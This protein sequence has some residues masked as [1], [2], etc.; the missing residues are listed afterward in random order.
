MAKKFKSI[1]TGL[2]AIAVLSMSLQSC[3]KDQEDVFDDPAAQRLTDYLK[4]AQKVLVGAENGWRMY[5]YPDQKQ[6]YGGFVYTL[7]FTEDEVTV[8]SEIFDG[9]YTSK[10][11][12][13]RD[14]SAV[15]SFDTNNYAFHYFATPSGS[16]RNL[17]NESGLYQAYKGD[18][19]FLILSATKDEVVLK[20]KRS[21][22]LIKMYP[23]SA[24][25]DAEQVT[26]DV[27]NTASSVYVSQFV[28]E[29][30]G[31]NYL[32]YLDLDYRWISLY[33]IVTNDEGEE[34]AESEPIAESAFA[35][36][37]TGLKLYTPVTLGS[38]TIEEIGWDVDSASIIINGTPIKGQLPEGWHPYEDFIGKWTL[39]Y[40][41][42]T[43]SGINIAEDVAGKS[44]TIT[45][46][47]NQFES[48]KA[49]YSLAS[50]GIGINSQIVGNNGTYDVWMCAWAVDGGGSLSWGTAYGM[51]GIFDPEDDTTFY[52]NDNGNWSGYVVDSFIL[53]YLNGSTSAGQAAS[54][55]VWS[56]N[57]TQ[58]ARWK[59]CVR[60]E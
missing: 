26:V 41:G 38:T 27:Y 53:W 33:E 49:T 13:T 10:Y 9:D 37:E 16:S 14:D 7:K 22:S 57:S 25:E 44:Y 2:L 21:R 58:L 19:E 34:V 52:W 31:K 54:P 47:S 15:L 18:F 60:A 59:S 51:V 30:N 12:M 20:G 24:S 50:G 32:I 23:L 43:L 17:Y 42:R 56:N 11:K 8:Y 29:L 55:W 35:Y 36:T 45:G 40:N 39:N 6:S 28:G 5:Y 48:V 3:L 4:A 1:L 46:L